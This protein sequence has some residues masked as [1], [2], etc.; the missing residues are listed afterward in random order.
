MCLLDFVDICDHET[1]TEMENH[2]LVTAHGKSTAAALVL[3]FFLFSS[4]PLQRCVGRFL[5]SWASPMVGWE[6]GVLERTGVM[7]TQH[8]WG[9]RGNTNAKHEARDAGVGKQKCSL[10][11]QT[12]TGNEPRFCSSHPGLVL[13]SFVNALHLS[14]NMPSEKQKQKRVLRTLF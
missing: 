2:R 6:C 8:L 11:K 9:K 7:D 1:Q 4:R 3:W 10:S 14:K 12:T 5:S 13:R